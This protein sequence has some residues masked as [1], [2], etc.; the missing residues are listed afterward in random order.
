MELGGIEIAILGSGTDCSISDVVMPK[1]TGFPS[2]CAASV[3]RLSISRLRWVRVSLI[4]GAVGVA[5]RGGEYG[6]GLTACVDA[7]LGAAALL[8]QPGGSSSNTPGG[9][10]GNPLFITPP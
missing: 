4:A 3:H 8:V 5:I 9:G 1:S 2:C 6:S 10:V 7:A